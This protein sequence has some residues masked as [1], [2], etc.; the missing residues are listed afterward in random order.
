[1]AGL[2][3]IFGNADGIGSAARFD[4]PEGVA[5]DSTGKVYVADF[6]LNTIRK[7]YPPP[8]FRNSEIIADQFFSVLT[9]PPGQLMIVEASTDLLSWLPIWTNTF[10]GDLNF[11]DQQSNVSSNHFY[12]A[13]TP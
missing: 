13:R 3:G 1:M 4:F 6:Y 5:V 8:M 12:R 2:A 9:G 10:A 11:S 7:G